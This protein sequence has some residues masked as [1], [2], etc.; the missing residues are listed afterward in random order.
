MVKKVT[1]KLLV[2]LRNRLHVNEMKTTELPVADVESVINSLEEHVREVAEQVDARRHVYY[3]DEISEIDAW[4][5]TRF[6]KYLQEGETLGQRIEHAI[7]NGFKKGYGRVV[8]VSTDCPQLSAGDIQKA[9]DLLNKKQVVMGPKSDGTIYLIGFSVPCLHIFKDK[10]WGSSDLF[11]KLYL[12][13]LKNGRTIALL[14]EKSHKGLG[15]FL[16]DK[17]NNEEI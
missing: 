4:S 13:L 11:K 8:L 10:P 6:I 16:L 9:F 15:E 17:M 12:D 14:E 3:E 2:V 7:Q 5:K 1:D